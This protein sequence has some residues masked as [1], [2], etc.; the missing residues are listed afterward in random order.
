MIKEIKVNEN[1]RHVIWVGLAQ[2]VVCWLATARLL[3]RSSTP[4]SKLSIEVH[5]SRTSPPNGLA[6][7]HLAC[8]TY[9]LSMERFESVLN[10]KCIHFPACT[11]FYASGSD[12]WFLQR[13]I[14]ETFEVS[15][16]PSQRLDRSLTMSLTDVWLHSNGFISKHY[17][18]KYTICGQGTTRHVY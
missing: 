7:C 15:T 1:E 3:V 6:V 16:F 13:G 2:E 14:S 11:I 17:Q 5:L 10:S 12:L 8:L 18:C 4:A 9:G